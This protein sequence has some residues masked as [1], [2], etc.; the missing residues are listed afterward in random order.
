MRDV[1]GGMTSN[2]FS[3]AELAFEVTAFAATAR[4]NAQGVLKNQEAAQTSTGGGGGGERGA[5][6]LCTAARVS[7]ATP[8]QCQL[9]CCSLL[10][11]GAL[12]APCTV[13]DPGS[14]P[15]PLSPPAILPHSSTLIASAA[16]PSRGGP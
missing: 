16:S 7:L 3:H 15:P 8:Q 12:Q 10:K 1:L 13:F 2:A 4:H 11:V 14:D 5:E 6:I 9:M